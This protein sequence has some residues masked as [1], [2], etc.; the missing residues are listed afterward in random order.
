MC[1]AT[2]R[3]C[4]EIGLPIS[5]RKIM[6]PNCETLSKDLLAV[7]EKKYGFTSRYAFTKK[8]KEYNIDYNPFVSEEDKA[9]WKVNYE[10]AIRASKSYKFLVKMK[11]FFLGI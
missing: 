1:M 10:V 8:G 2:A 6:H 7:L 3:Q 11:E 4:R 5:K 9:L